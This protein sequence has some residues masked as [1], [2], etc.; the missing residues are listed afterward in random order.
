MKHVQQKDCSSCGANFTCGPEGTDDKCWC[1]HLPHVS[2]VASEDQ[3]CLCP[4]CLREAIE[5]LNCLGSAAAK[6]VN[7]LRQTALNPQPSLVEGEDYYLEGGMLIFT[8]SYHL[9]RGYCCE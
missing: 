8:E 3:N 2:F 6:G 7:P 1:E 4:R 5:E 9:R